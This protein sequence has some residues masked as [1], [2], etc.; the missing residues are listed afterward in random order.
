MHFILAFLFAG[1]VCLIAQIILDNTKLTPGHITSIFTVIGALL[2]FMGIY[3]KLIEK[4]G[5][6]ATILISNFG[7]LLYS[8]GIKGY[9]DEGFLGIFTGLLCKSS[10]AITGAVVFAFI[11]AI[12]FKPKN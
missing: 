1:M 5:A 6:G 3:E 10:L 8:S 7:H 2:S 12:I 4:F 11:F 9:I